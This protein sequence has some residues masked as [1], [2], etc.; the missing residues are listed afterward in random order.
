MPGTH[1]R[2]A[3]TTRSK[4]R[5]SPKVTRTAI[6][7]LETTLSRGAKRNLIA[8]AAAVAAGAAITG[9]FVMRLR[10]GKLAKAAAEDAVSIGHTVG[11]LGH[12]V[13]KSLGREV[14]ELDLTRLLTYAGLKRRPSLARRLLPPIGALA[15]LA[16]AGGSAV[17]LLRAKLD[18]TDDHAPLRGSKLRV[19]STLK[20]DAI[21]DS[22]TPIHNSVSS[23][24]DEVKAEVS[25]AIK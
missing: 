16:F 23:A 12:R 10:I 18:E 15:A 24:I 4:A 2:G 14:T 9:V 8:G 19:P 25:H 11:S 13:G 1:K 7:V 5:R 20:G 21:G 3:R 22:A 17:F 6:P